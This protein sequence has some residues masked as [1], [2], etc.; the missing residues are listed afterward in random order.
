MK[1]AFIIT[2]SILSC[3]ILVLSLFLY[4]TNV[5]L[6]STNM[7]LEN[8]YQ[9]SFYDLVNN[10]NNMEVEVSKLMVSND[11]TSQQK[12][13]SKLKQQSSDAE[14]SL[15]LLPIN[16]NIL[17]KTTRFMNQFNGYCT[18]LITYKDGKIENEDYETL[19]NVYNSISN[20]KIELNKIME[21]I[22]KGYRIS[23]N[24]NGNDVNSDFSLNFSSL[25]NDTIEYP[26]LIYDGPFS[27]STLKKS[28]KGLKSTEISENDA[29]NLITKI[30]DNKITNLNFLG[31]TNSNFVTF[32][33]GVNTEDGKNY[34]IQITKQGG[35]LLTISSNV[36]N[37]NLGSVTTEVVK[38]DNSSGEIEIAEETNVDESSINKTE[39]STIVK[40][41]SIN[42]L[43][44][45][46][47][48]AIDTAENF[49]KKL[50]LNDM[51]CVWSA[52]SEEISYI[53]L[54]PV[55]DD[56]IMYPDLIKVK[57]DLKNNSL[58]GWEATSY[59]YNHTER[60]DLI[61]QLSEEEARKLVSSNLDINSQKLCVIPLDYVGETLA[62][63]FAGKYNDFNYYLYIDAYNGSQVRILKVVQTDEGELVL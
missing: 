58:V 4:S 39:E 28:I 17:E 33:F 35:F 37:D 11:S 55:I 32:D 47:E 45:E 6:N 63:E 43:T 61:P 26:S 34:F 23:D 24:L 54:A 57:V 3:V 53:N 8:L 25:S 36:L 44:S 9:R 62:Y 12:S 31:E 20:I 2:V 48:K 50:G 1:K 15:S 19:G 60:D 29:E 38:D 52:A 7:N 40:V 13:L 27:D 16:E 21:K 30:F 46:I 49:A 42:N 22:M 41:E 10:V 59:A 18:S 5:S 56:I 51:K 14:N